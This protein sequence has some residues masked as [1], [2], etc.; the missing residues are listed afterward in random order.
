M[1]RP[2]HAEIGNVG[3][4]PWQNLRIVGGDVRVRA[5]NRRDMGVYMPFPYTDGRNGYVMYRPSSG[6]P[7]NGSLALAR[8]EGSVAVGQFHSEGRSVENRVQH[9]FRFLFDGKPDPARLY[10]FRNKVY[11][12]QKIEANVTDTGL[13]RLMTGYFYEML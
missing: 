3:R 10:M 2:R 9:V 8:T 12:C 5:G 13:D 4:A 7:G 1:D 6:Q 11:E